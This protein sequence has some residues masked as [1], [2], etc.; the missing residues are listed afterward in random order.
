MCYAVVYAIAILC[1]IPLVA[2][3]KEN[4]F[5]CLKNPQCIEESLRC[6]GFKDCLDGTDEWY[7]CTRT[8]EAPTIFG[9]FYM[10]SQTHKRSQNA[11]IVTHI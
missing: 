8:T 3:C 4:E 7:N 6:N 11:E 2:A 9:M 1:A 5:T 10:G